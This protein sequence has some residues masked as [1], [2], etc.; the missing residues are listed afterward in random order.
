MVSEIPEV[1]P[2][3]ES[4]TSLIPPVSNSHSLEFSPSSP[5][6]PNISIKLASTNYLLWKAQVIPILCGN[7]LLGYVQNQVPRP[8]QTIIGEDGVSWT[9]PAAAIWLHTDQLILGWISSSLSD[10][11]LSQVISSESSHDAWHVLE[12]LYG[13]YTWDRL[14]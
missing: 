7:G 8:S 11:P 10:G 1:S 9:N 5:H 13:S 4:S 14:Q 3:M 12:T 2:T 6:L